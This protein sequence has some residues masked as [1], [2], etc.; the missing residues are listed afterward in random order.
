MASRTDSPRVIFVFSGKRK[1]G[2]DYV[3]SL[4]QERFG[5]SCIILRLS[6]P[7]KQQ[8]AKEN[9]LDFKKLLDASEYK[10]RYRDDMIKWG[11]RIRQKDSSYFCRLATD[12]AKPHHTIWIVSD[13]RRPSDIEYFKKSYPDQTITVRVDT[14]LEVRVVRGFVFTPG[15]DDAPSECGLDSYSKWNVVLRN[16][17]NQADLEN[18]L[19]LLTYMTKGD[20]EVKR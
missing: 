6:G 10:E 4:L 19:Q 2:K 20:G 17:G 16:N 13:A 7:L 1:S 9:N 12:E 11:E 18:Q 15:I 14:D 8:Y 5:S 3:T